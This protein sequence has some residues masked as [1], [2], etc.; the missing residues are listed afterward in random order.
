MP[1]DPG[2]PNGSIYGGGLL[3]GLAELGRSPEQIEAVAFSHLHP[4]HLGW[5]V[6]PVPGTG[7]RAFAHADH[8][9]AEPEWARY[10]QPE[11]DGTPDEAIA[12]LAPHVRTMTDGQ[13]IFPGVQVRSPPATPR[14]TRSSSSPEADDASSPSATHAFT[15]PGRPPRVVLRLRP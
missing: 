1:A 2:T 3:N 4:D 8:L 11:T 15:G 12:A 5:A 6:H 7:A 10:A 14:D 13:Y 9:V